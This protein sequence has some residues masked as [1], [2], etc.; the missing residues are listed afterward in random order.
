MRPAASVTDVIR[1][2]GV[3]LEAHRRAIGG[4]ETRQTAAGVV[5]I[6][7]R[8]AAGLG[9][10]GCAIVGIELYRHVAARFDLPHEVSALVVLQRRDAVLVVGDRA[11]PSKSVVGNRRLPPWQSTD[12]LSSPSG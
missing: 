9:R 5:D 2:T 12:R 7:R 11:Q 8:A 6:P 1:P 4:N 10:A 3:V